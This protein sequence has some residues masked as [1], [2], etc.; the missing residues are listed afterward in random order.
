MHTY[1]YSHFQKLSTN[2]RIAKNST[3]TALIDTKF[4]RKVAYKF[5]YKTKSIFIYGNENN[6]KFL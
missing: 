5:M 4:G 3:N 2:M 1:K 6:I